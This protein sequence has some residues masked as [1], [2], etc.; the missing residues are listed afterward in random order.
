MTAVDGLDYELAEL[1]DQ[2]AAL[3]HPSWC[4][5][6]LCCVSHDNDGSLVGF[7]ERHVA[8]V[9]IDSWQSGDLVL[10]VSQ[11]AQD[12]APVVRVAVYLDDVYGSVPL[13]LGDVAPLLA[14]I[15]A[16]AEVAR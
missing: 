14:A 15:T 3:G 9:A 8:T 5:K 4:D 11:F 16:A 12:P 7:H 1:L 2:D 10:S 13:A 6:G